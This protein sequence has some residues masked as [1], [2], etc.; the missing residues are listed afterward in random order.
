MSA[1]YLRIG[2]VS[3]RTGVTRELLRAWERRYG[4]LEPIRSSGGFR[5]YGDD[6]LRRVA[7]MQR[8]LADGLSAAEAARFAQLPVA[9]RPELAAATPGEAI[10][11][12]LDALAAFDADAAHAVIDSRLAAYSLPAFLSDLVLPC[13]REL[14]LRWEDGRATIA[15]EHFASSLLHGRLLGLTRSWDAGEGSR[16]LLACAPGEQHDLP[17][18]VFGIALRELGWRVT[19]LGQDTPVLTLAEAARDLE[20]HVVVVSAHAGSQFDGAREQL[21]ALAAR[22]RVAIGGAGS[23]PELAR[24]IGAELLLGDPV[25]AAAELQN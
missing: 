20:P 22:H 9:P 17:L 24:A 6:D 15:Q 4:L 11:Q 13:L 12:L 18:L 21:R 7:A 14:G 8:H 10:E 3:R 2:E 19:Y 5:L 25:G 16:A 1:G 23:T